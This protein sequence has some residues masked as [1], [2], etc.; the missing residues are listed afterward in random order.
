MGDESRIKL[1]LELEIEAGEPM[2]GWVGAS[3]HEPDRFEGVLELMA[4][5]DHLRASGAIEN[6][7]APKRDP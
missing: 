3:G 7:P 5:I 6:R 4:R 2:T 1:E